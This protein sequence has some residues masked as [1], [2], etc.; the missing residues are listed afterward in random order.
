MFCVGLK[1]K[2]LLEENGFNVVAY[3]GY[4][5]DL[6]EIITLI[7]STEKY[8]FFSG[9][10]RRD[11]LPNALKESNIVFNEIEVYETTLTPQKDRIAL[12]QTQ[13]CFSVRQ[14]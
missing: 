6:A 4:A 1:T 13:S 14:A 11:T 10:M 8:T 3:T 9:N 7:Y 12:N 2:A 5:A